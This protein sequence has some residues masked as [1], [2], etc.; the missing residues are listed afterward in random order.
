LLQAWGAGCGSGDDASPDDPAADGGGGAGRGEADAG[1]EP[2]TDAAAPVADGGGAGSGPWQST[3]GMCDLDSGY[4]GDDTCLLPPAPGEG[5]QIRV[6]PP[7]YSAEDVEPWLMDAGEES[8]QCYFFTTPNSEEVWYQTWELSG[9]PGTHHI[10]NTALVEAQPDGFSVCMDMGLGNSPNTKGLLP[11]ASRAYMPRV[12]VAPENEQLGAMLEPEQGAQADMHYFNFGQE[13]ILREF[14]LNLYTVDR[15]QITED[16]NPIRGMGGLSWL[17]APIQP[18]THQTYTYQCPIAADGRIVRLIG[19]THKHGIRETA[20]IVSGDERLK[21]FEQFDYL[22]PQ[23]FEYN[24][25][26]ENPDFAPNQPGAFTGILNVKAGDVLEWECEV[27]NTSNVALRYTNF[28]ETG[29]M[30]N[31]WGEAVG[32]LLDCVVF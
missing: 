23:I 21:V 1:A 27:N 20:W 17:L 9:R 14:W 29:E 5:I 12:Q 18:G 26:V 15:A 30:C 11:G 10:I 31:I 6:G 4:L 2:A 16:G 13:R 25:V 32:P 19:H 24:S 7:S 22:E 28:V 8:S 3:R